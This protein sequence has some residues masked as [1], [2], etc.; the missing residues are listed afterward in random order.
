MAPFSI[1]KWGNFQLDYTDYRMVC[2]QLSLADGV[3]RYAWV[4]TRGITYHVSLYA[5]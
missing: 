5:L 3:L 2:L 1:S 4:Y